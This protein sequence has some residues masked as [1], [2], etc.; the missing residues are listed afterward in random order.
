MCGRDSPVN[1]FICHQEK[2]RTNRQDG[3]RT[4]GRKDD[5]ANKKRH[6][7]E[8]E[9]IEK[10]IEIKCEKKDETT[11]NTIDLTHNTI[12]LIVLGVVLE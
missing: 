4:E 11:H 1:R 8:R 5:R 2:T 6:S 7:H 9:R 3:R 12:D 10:S